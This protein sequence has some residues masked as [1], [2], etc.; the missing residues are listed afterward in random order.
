MVIDARVHSVD[1]SID[2]TR[3]YLG[4]IVGSP[5]TLDV[6]TLQGFVPIVPGALV[7]VT[8][9]IGDEPRKVP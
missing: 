6:F 3:L 7:T 5:V 4:P 8:I 1:A 9:A 2:R